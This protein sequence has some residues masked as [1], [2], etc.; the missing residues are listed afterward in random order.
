MNL[1]GF[2]NWRVVL[3]F[4]VAGPPV[5]ALVL[6]LLLE[7]SA[8][9]RGWFAGPY[10]SLAIV[11]GASYIAGLLPAVVAGLIASPIWASHRVRQTWWIRSAIG[12]ALGYVVMLLVLYEQFGNP[13]VFG[14]P[15][16]FASLGAAGGAVSG[17]VAGQWAAPNNSFKPMPLRGTA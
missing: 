4:S 1:R 5:G 7:G 15:L 6:M 14:D 16:V 8:A 3:T 11:L 12:A 10:I 17:L 13:E 2:W 9:G